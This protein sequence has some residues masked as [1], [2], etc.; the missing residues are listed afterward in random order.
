MKPSDTYQLL[1]DSVGQWDFTG[2]FVPG[3]LLLTGDAAF[4]VVVSPEKQVVIAVSQ[5]GK[6]RMVVVSHEAILENPNFSQFLRNAVDWLRPSP[7]A[8]VGVHRSLDPLSQLLLGSSTK[9]QP[10]VGFSASLGVYCTHAYDDAQAEELVQF[11]KRGGG[12]LIGG[13]AWFWASQ[14][15]AEKVLFDFPGNRV[16]SVAGVYFTGNT[17]GTGSF[18]VSRKIPKIPLI[19]Q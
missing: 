13:Q 8:Q 7:E 19:V 6:G 14:H 9:V 10:G 5:Y 18:K 11:V 12:L 15:D 1:V 4:P 16:T 2:D 3:E 17:V